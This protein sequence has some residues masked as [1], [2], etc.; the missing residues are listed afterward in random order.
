[1]PTPKSTYKSG[2][3]ETRL[4]NEAMVPL[5]LPERLQ[6]ATLNNRC[7]ICSEKYH[8]AKRAQPEA[9]DSDLQKCC[10]TVYWCKS[11]EVFLCIGSG[12]EN[13]FETYHLKVQY[14]Q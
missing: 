11:C 5:H 1:M 3:N 10:K 8:K 6:G 12:N 2:L 13:C 4:Q 7:V 9:R 14:W